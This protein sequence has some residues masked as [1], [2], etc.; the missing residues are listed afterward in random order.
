[1]LRGASPEEVETAVTK[2]LEDVI[3]TIEGVDELN[4]VSREGISMINI[5]FVYERNR[6]SA[7]QDVRDKVN[8]ILARLPPGTETPIVDKFDLD[9]IPVLSITVTAPRHLKEIS[10]VADKQLKQNL[11]TVRDVGAI[12]IVGSRIRAVQVEVDFDRLRAYGLTVGDVQDA[13]AQQNVEVPGG[14]VEQGPREL[15]VRTLGR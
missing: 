4:S 8:S 3:N 10:D 7:A 12:N 15:V 11:E 14:R 5:Q 1:T 2:P 13:L 6:D 9:S